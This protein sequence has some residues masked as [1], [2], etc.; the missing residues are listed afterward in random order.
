MLQKKYLSLEGSK[1]N[2]RVL[3]AVDMCPGSSSHSSSNIFFSQT[4]NLAFMSV[5]I[6]Q[7]SEKL[8][9]DERNLE[10]RRKRQSIDR[11]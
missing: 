4:T 3:V 2:P 9:K 8:T 11:P 5:L 1:R 6:W 7:I 10:E